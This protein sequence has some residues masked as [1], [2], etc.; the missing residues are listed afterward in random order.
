MAHIRIVDMPC[1]YGKSSLILNTFDRREKYIAVVPYLTEVQ[2]FI[3]DARAQSSFLLTEPLQSEGSKRDHCERLIRDRKSIACT[4]ALFYRLGTLATQR[5]DKASLVD[6]QPGQSPVVRTGHLLDDYH[7][8][9][10]EVVDPFEIEQTVRQTDFDED[11]I[12]MGLAVVHSD[13][14]VEPTELWDE[15]YRAG[16]KTF[17][18]ALYQKAKSGG[19]YRLGETLFVLTIPTEL[20][21]RPK[22]VTIYTYLSEGSVL[23]HFLRKLQAERPGEFTLEV[24]RLSQTKEA[25]WREDVANALTVRSVS[26]VE[27]QPWTHMAQLKQIKTHKQCASVGHRLRRF[28]NDELKGGDLGTVMLT[29][30]R[31]LWHG[32]TNG[33]KPVAGR[34]AKHTRLFGRV[35]K[36]EVYDKDMQVYRNLW[37]TTGVRFVPNTTRGTNAHVGCSTAV[38]LY[39][40]HPN[41]QLL[42]F[43]GMKRNSDAAYRFSD[44]YAL[45]EL[46]QWLFR[47]AIRVGGLNM[48][49]RAY[50]PRKKVTVYIPSERMRNLL[51]NWLLT[52]RVSS[53]PVKAEGPRQ[54][55][56]LARMTGVQEAAVA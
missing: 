39:D 19:L 31:E 28:K 47:S 11:Y 50:T 41:P 24:E 17:S 5:G 38:Y 21:L 43:L 40:Q 15:K 23:L 49:G 29:C 30:A 45:A 37:S 20:L 7:L 4:H 52:G 48:T 3:P 13:G 53:G 1:G 14:R 25:A 35:L 46:V 22:S 34:L 44:A 12:K 36:E 10:D 32:S 26:D 51:L 16:S 8:I 18:P 6:W 27:Q 2:R 42:T 56:L 33:K 55:E 54:T 9:I